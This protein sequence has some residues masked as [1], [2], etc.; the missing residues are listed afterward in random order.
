MYRSADEARSVGG[1]KHLWV[2]A[3]PTVLRVGPYRFFFYSRE[4]QEPPHIHVEA[5]GKSGKL[6]LD[7][8]SV[9]RQGHFSDNE[10]NNIADIAR[11]NQHT[12]IEAWHDYFN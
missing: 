8:V 12:L 2:R 11:A 3:M 7:P 4:G 9:A 1:T 5:A 6:W 10:M